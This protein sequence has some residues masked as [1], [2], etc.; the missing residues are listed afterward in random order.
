MFHLY[1]KNKLD[2]LAGRFLAARREH[3]EHFLSADLLTP[4]CVIVQ[5]RGMATYLQQYWLRQGEVVCNTRFPF[6][7]HYLEE[8]LRQQLPQGRYQ[9]QWFTPGVMVW[10]ILAL[11][12]ETAKRFDRL[13]RYFANGDDRELRQYQLALRIAGVFDQYQ[14]YRPDL[15]QRW[16]DDGAIAA[17]DE[18]WQ[19]DLWQKLRQ[20]GKLA[21]R[22][23]MLIDFIRQPEVRPGPPVSVF[24]VSTMPP[25]FLKALKKYSL[26]NEVNFFYLNPCTEYWAEH[27]MRRDK[28]LRDCPDQG[29]EFVNPLL[30]A[31]GLPGRNFFREI[32]D[33]DHD[34]DEKM[35]FY[36]ESADPA[37]APSTMLSE[38]QSRVIA[39]AGGPLSKRH[40]DSITFHNCPGKMREIEILHDKLLYL[41]RQKHYTLNDI[42]VM[43]PDINEFVP[44][45]QSVF[46]RGPLRDSYSICDRTVRSTNLAAAAF[47]NLLAMRQGRFEVTQVWELL[48]SPELRQKFAFDDAAMELVR[49][50]IVI[51]DAPGNKMSLLVT[52]INASDASSTHGNTAVRIDDS[53]WKDAIKSEA[54]IAEFSGTKLDYKP[55][56]VKD[57]TG[58][59]QASFISEKAI[60][61]ELVKKIRASKKGSSIKV[62]MF[63]L[64]EQD[65]IK[66]LAK[67]AKRGVDVKII[68]D[69]NKDSFGRQRDGT[70]NRPAAN[71]LYELSDKL[72]KIRWYNTNGE[73]CHGKMFIFENSGSYSMIQGSCNMTRRNM[74]N[75]NLE[76]DIMIE[77]GKKTKFFDK[78]EG[79][80]NRIWSNDDGNTYTVDFE[81]YRDT[82]VLLRLKYKLQ[83]MTGWC[84]F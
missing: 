83:E 40:D 35:D 61:R 59:T 54:G 36:I 84:S 51:A 80:F 48:D 82:R 15:L 66:E 34:I 73:Q 17:A 21:G 5:T 43:A 30:S 41:L 58:T 33:L 20:G 72:A 8:L 81:K 60:K 65:I 74:D 78:A 9:P 10:R 52:S 53:V 42:I 49:P 18:A 22:G 23:E 57:K 71:E 19:R 12:P 56:E 63:Y 4:E 77:S 67:A 27:P 62:V 79:Y 75:L 47:L 28:S 46:D 32:L 1:S 16:M 70:P 39:V 14:I 38:V 55:G 13:E 76:A 45:I 26:V 31:F 37:A 24:G 11:L 29:L 64:S 6:L 68:L 69:P 25:F 7:N 44:L 2:E 50:S 3:C